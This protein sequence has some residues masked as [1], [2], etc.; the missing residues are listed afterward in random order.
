MFGQPRSNPETKEEVHLRL[1][2]ALTIVYIIEDF[3][4]SPS[5]L[6][7]SNL[8]GALLLQAPGCD[9]HFDFI[10]IVDEHFPEKRG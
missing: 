3:S 10:S 9:E 5:D 2:A 7:I 6:A 8:F 1:A 4:L